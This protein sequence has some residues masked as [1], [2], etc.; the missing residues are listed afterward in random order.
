MSAVATLH[1]DA[2]N[3]LYTLT[4]LRI[5]IY[6]L[7]YNNY[8]T[9]LRDRLSQT[10]YTAILVH[11]ILSIKYYVQVYINRKSL[12]AF[13]YCCTLALIILNILRLSNTYYKRKN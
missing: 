9:N 5:I 13:S 6:I 8:S 4:D 2:Y 1:I 3:M 10:Y 7:I 12:N 11:F